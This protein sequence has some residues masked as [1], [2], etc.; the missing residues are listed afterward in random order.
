MPKSLS[1]SSLGLV[2]FGALPP[3]LIPLMTE[4]HTVYLFCFSPELASAKT[5]K[6]MHPSF[7]GIPK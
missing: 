3:T 7:I 6:F 5:V 1:N 2:K 4:K